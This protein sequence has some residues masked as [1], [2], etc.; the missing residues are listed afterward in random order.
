ME[1]EN[2]LV[3][4]LDPTHHPPGSEDFTDGFV[5][6]PESNA[7]GEEELL[8]IT[9]EIETFHHNETGELVRDYVPTPL[10]VL[11]PTADRTPVEVLDVA[12]TPQDVLP[13]APAGELSLQDEEEGNAL[14][15][16]E[17][18]TGVPD[19]NGPG[20]G[21]SAWETADELIDTEEPLSEPEDVLQPN[22][23]ERLDV[24]EPDT[25]EEEGPDVP[26]TEELLNVEI[27]EP[28]E[29]TVESLMPGGVEV[30]QT[31]EEP[32]MGLA[33]VQ[34]P[35]QG[36]EEA[37]E[38]N[39][40]EEGEGLD[41]VTGQ[42]E[43]A[44]GSEETTPEPPDV[45]VPEEEV[46]VVPEAED[47][48]GGGQEEGVTDSP[49]PDEPN[50][51]KPKSEP[52]S[53]PGETEPPRTGTTSAESEQEVVEAAEEPKEV[54]LDPLPD[55][56]EPQLPAGPEDGADPEVELENPESAD[57][58]PPAEKFPED[59][60]DVPQPTPED[61]DYSEP[62][63]SIKILQ[64]DDDNGNFKAVEKNPD[65][66]G[67]S[68]EENSI[69]PDGVGG[70]DSES[71]VTEEDVDSVD[72]QVEGDSTVG[73]ADPEGEATETVLNV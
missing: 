8:I 6:S 65:Y 72:I 63:E 66:R 39:E 12:P 27:S 67:P 33:E 10:V 29:T 54:I 73:Q 17:G 57:V 69:P 31:E 62:A 24:S 2:S 1:K 43:K 61:G 18:R 15:E 40:T 41:E 4:L 7:G 25:E 35:D 14:P 60:D 32:E 20:E 19:P 21:L 23:E 11:H 50:L 48:D 3:T 38:P 34:H 68:E 22:P 49:A 28:D 30:L 52:E 37:P 58:L 16:Q 70:P 59:G 36:T 5:S 71:P 56:S 53:V 45:Q 46:G 42:K 64:P 26:E 13:P 55:L 47:K 44:A 51:Q 9:Y